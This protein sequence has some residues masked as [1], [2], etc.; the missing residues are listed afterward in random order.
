MQA[1]AT[2]PLINGLSDQFHPCQIL[3]DLL[4][5]QEKFNHL[6]GLT[7]GYLGDGNNILNT[8][9]IM[10]PLLGIHIHYCTP[11]G[12][13]PSAE[14]L[15]QAM[16]RDNGIDNIQAF[17]EPDAAVFGCHAVYTDVWTSMGFTPSD[18]R[19]FEGFQV[20]E[21]LMAKAHSEA[22]FLHCMPMERGK[23]VSKTLPDQPCSAVFQQS[24]NRLHVQK[25]LLLSLL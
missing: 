4:T 20:N 22:I 16:Q 25:A 24:E 15:Q 13:E 19:L 12:H 21:Q 6:A 17:T 10:A 3:A 7:I 9:L 1:V 18:D 8:L 2:I 14:L 5:L 11:K 23:E